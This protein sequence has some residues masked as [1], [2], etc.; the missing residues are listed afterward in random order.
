MKQ[1]PM[2]AQWVLRRAARRP[3]PHPG[4]NARRVVAASSLRRRLAPASWA[5]LEELEAPIA[6]RQVAEVAEE[7]D[8]TRPGRQRRRE[9]QK[10][11]RLTRRA[12]SITR[13]VAFDAALT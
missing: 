6:C 4:A 11:F 2:A 8:S 1:L 9:L 10:N 13:V 7:G 3:G 5:D 12:D